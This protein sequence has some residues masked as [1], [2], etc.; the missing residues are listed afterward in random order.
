MT[1]WFELEK[2]YYMRTFDRYPVTLVRGEGARVW[3]DANKQYLDFFGGLAVTV[4]GHSHPVVTKAITEQ[5]QTL[6]QT[7]NLYYTIPQLQMAELLVQNSCLQRVFYAN[8][9]AEVNEGAVKLARRYGKLKLGGAYEVITV[10]NSFHGRTLAM[11]AATG[12]VKMQ[13]PYKP[14]PEGFKNV[15]F[16]NLDALKLAIGDR[17]CSI[18][19][20]L[21]Q[22][23]GGVNI[24]AA[25]YYQSVRELCD[26]KG[27][28]LILDEIQTGMGRLGTLWGYQQFG[29]EPDVMTLAKGL[30]NGVPIGALLAKEHASVFVPGDHGSTF[31]GNP[32]A[33]AA[34]YATLKYVIENDISG[35][36]ARVGNYF[37]TGLKSLQQKYSFVT[38]VRGR[39]LLLAMEFNKDIGQQALLQCLKEGLLV[40]KVKP[41]VLRFMPPLIITEREADEALNILD[42]VLAGFVV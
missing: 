37:M 18:M 10:T 23:E 34:G 39:G 17:T 33:C 9:G 6:L 24:P 22:G 5:A 14:M 31:G 3:D 19:L 16:N 42:G 15:E 26:R 20:E 1:S 28:L 13:E 25:G 35:N 40:N 2:K 21:V 36:S 11:T 32:L 12:Q 41:N 29:I 27:I 7:S 30:A 38:D 4:L 8:S